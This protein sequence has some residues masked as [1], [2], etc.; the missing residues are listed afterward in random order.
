MEPIPYN[1]QTNKKIYYF[2][3]MTIPEIF[4][5]LIVAVLTITVFKSPMLMLLAMFIYMIYLALFRVNKPDGYDEHLFKSKWMPTL[6]RPC[7]LD[8]VYPI[9][10][11][12]K[13]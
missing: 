1:R 12:K 3:V 6:L 13:R 2:G 10:I 9:K 5:M 7:K 8:P 4:I 11:N